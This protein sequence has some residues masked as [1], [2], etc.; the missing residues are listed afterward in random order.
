ME[1]PA[2]QSSIPFAVRRTPWYFSALAYLGAT[3]TT[4]LLL[5]YGMRLD[6]LSYEDYKAPFTYKQD[7]LLI[8]PFVKAT[9]ERGSHWRNERLSAPGIQ[10]LH[11][12]PVIDHLHF[13]V[14]WVLG[15][16]LKEPIVTFNAFY[17]LTYPLTTLSGMFVL[18]RFRLTLP[19]AAAGGLL[20]S[21][22]PYH[23]MRE[24]V[25][26][27]L[28][29][30]Y[31]VPLTLMLTLW[32]CQG[33]LPFFPQRPDS[34]R[35][36]RFRDPLGWVGVLIAILT[37]CGGAYYAFFACALLAA[38]GVYGWFA[39]HTWRAAMSAAIAL[40]MVG[41]AGLA[42]HAP[43]I[44]YQIEYGHNTRPTARYSEEAEIYGMKIAQLVLPVGGHNWLPLARMRSEYDAIQRR[45]SQNENE[46]GAFGIV[47]A[48]GYIGLIVVAFLPRRYGWPLGALSALAL[49]ATLL[50]TIGGLGAIFNH[51]VTPQVR[52]VNR[53]SI[54]IAFLAL[55]A[56]VWVVD[57]YF[58]TRRGR[59][60]HMLWPAFI[61]LIGV[62]MWDQLNNTWFRDADEG[63]P[64]DRAKVAKSFWEDRRFF[65]KVEQMLADTADRIP[66]EYR[67]DPPAVYN[68]PYQPFPEAHPI[69]D[70]IYSY[71]HVRGYL[72]TKNVRW[73]FGAMTG[74]EWDL[75]FRSLVDEPPGDL[76][77]RLVYMG[78]RGLLVDTRAMSPAEFA[79]FDSQ[80]LN[81]I[82]NSAPRVLHKDASYA[83]YDLTLHAEYLINTSRSRYL[84]MRRIE[85]DG[86]S[87][88]WLRGFISYEAVGKEFKRLDCQPKAELILVNPSDKPR[89]V[90]IEMDLSIPMPSRTG[91][92][93]DDKKIDKREEKKD[94]KK[95]ER[96][97]DPNRKPIGMTLTSAIW[98]ETVPDLDD[99]P[100]ISTRVVVIP[101]GRHRVVLRCQPPP[102]YLPNDSRLTFLMIGNFRMVE[103]PL[104]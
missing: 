53:I 4:I 81:V 9:V 2:P 17:L 60:R 92:K 86:I 90:R 69:K 30:Y 22:Q 61:A 102:D 85:R 55:F 3:A 29:A 64:K 88:L 73:S 74:R 41:L 35:R 57:H 52:G 25:H 71:D 94:E 15:K 67:D 26:Y 10:E 58:A 48:L 91:D 28:S 32:I 93:F 23:Y 47:G 99:L 89:A 103:V 40:V 72:H 45:P 31:T 78:F 37:A 79:E 5:Y 63:Y 65:E 33:R 12:F 8:L 54:F 38:A 80:V 14:I 77:N 7:A 20:Y 59:M 46:W 13:A 66:A 16:V 21:F 56:S 49:F 101:P 87:V 97:D 84:E 82:T 98:N 24:E 100:K 96:K 42:N 68:Y 95:D 36:F 19:A 83:F 44:H 62:G 11:D 27:F 50:G 43:A 70:A 18:R 39:T 51:L 6:L 104:P 76:V 1:S 34:L 75:R